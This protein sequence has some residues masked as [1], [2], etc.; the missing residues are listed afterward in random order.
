M[1]LTIPAPRADDCMRTE[2]PEKVCVCALCL[3]VATCVLLTFCCCSRSALTSLRSMPLWNSSYRQRSPFSATCCLC[4]VAQ[5]ASLAFIPKDGGRALPPST[6]PHLTTT[7]H[8]YLTQHHLV[9]ADDPAMLLRYNHS[10]HDDFS[11]WSKT[12]I[13][14]SCAQGVYG[15]VCRLPGQGLPLRGRGKLF[16][17]DL[18]RHTSGYH[19]SD[20]RYQHQPHRD[21]RR[22]FGWRI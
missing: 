17:E 1:K 22:P 9:Q 19:V 11:H 6:R 21:S 4:H 3:P 5:D 8:C 13:T 20:I 10:H 15:R 14:L 18:Q 2:H 16:Q 7:W 12:Y